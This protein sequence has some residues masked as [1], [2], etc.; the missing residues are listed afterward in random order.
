M[1]VCSGP[2]A[3]LGLQAEMVK[4]RT[5]NMRNGVKRVHVFIKDSSAIIHLCEW[6]T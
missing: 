6:P 3:S 2:V 5:T 1:N 4:A